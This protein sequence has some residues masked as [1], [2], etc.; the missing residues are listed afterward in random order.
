MI[1]H[2]TRPSIAPTTLSKLAPLG[3]QNQLQFLAAL[4]AWKMKG[5]FWGVIYD[6]NNTPHTVLYQLHGNPVDLHDV[7]HGAT[8][9]VAQHHAQADLCANVV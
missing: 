7:I 1:V 8:R 5:K 3:A 4:F 9:K 2:M 6:I